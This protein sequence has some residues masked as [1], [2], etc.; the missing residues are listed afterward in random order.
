MAQVMAN[1]DR[2]Y[3]RLAQ[4]EYTMQ[5]SENRPKAFEKIENKF[6]DMAASIAE[7]HN[8]AMYSSGVVENRIEAMDRDMKSCQADIKS[9]ESLLK[10]RDQ[11]TE[12][13]N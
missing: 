12:R 10:L 7:K 13:T 11:Q 8:E 1:Q 4:L 6:A 9:M 5:M 3:N 2:I